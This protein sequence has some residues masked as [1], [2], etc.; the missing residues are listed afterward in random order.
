M[1]FYLNTILAVEIENK[2]NYPVR[3][4]KL[5]TK[6]VDKQRNN[7]WLKSKIKDSFLSPEYEKHY[8]SSKG[9]MLKN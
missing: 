5:K 2:G 6:V 4:I 9:V 7:G 3:N 1:D 8:L